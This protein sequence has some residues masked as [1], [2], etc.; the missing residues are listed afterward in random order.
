MLLI[1]VKYNKILISLF[2]IFNF[3]NVTAKNYDG[4]LFV[5]ADEIG[6][7]FE[8]EIPKFIN[9]STI[10]KISFKIYESTNRKKFYLSD[11]TIKKK[12]SPIDRTY[13]YYSVNF[14]DKKQEYFEL[15]P[16]S[17]LMLKNEGMNFSSLVCW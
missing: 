3:S 2:L 6:P 14:H 8:L 12:S 5:C 17:H 10:E 7:R 15:Y 4:K 16:P 11:G 13:F 9:E 1:N